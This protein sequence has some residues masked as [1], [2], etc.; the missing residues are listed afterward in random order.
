MKTYVKI[1]RATGQEIARQ[2]FENP[3]RVFHKAVVWLPLVEQPRPPF[4]PNTQKL[5]PVRTLPAGLSNLAQ[6]VDPTAEC[7]DSL[8]VLALTVEELNARAA[9]KVTNSEAHLN[10]PQNQTILSALWEMH[11]AI[12]GLASLPTET[13]AQYRERLKTAWIGYDT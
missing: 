3:G 7:I 2:N 10:T 1:E 9:Q 12:R 6:P 4:D 11:R 13:K 5:V 8:A